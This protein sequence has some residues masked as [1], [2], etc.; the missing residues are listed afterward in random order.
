MARPDP[1][2]CSQKCGK[3][4]VCACALISTCSWAKPLL[5][6]PKLRSIATPTTDQCEDLKRVS[7][8]IL[9]CVTVLHRLAGYFD[10]DMTAPKIVRPA[11]DT[12][13][14]ENARLE[15]RADFLNIR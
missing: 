3:G 6:R 9:H 11:K 2:I 4:D 12:I 8:N 7:M 13:L 14:G 5:V 1:N 10:V 15:F